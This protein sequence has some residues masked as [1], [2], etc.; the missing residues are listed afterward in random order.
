MW[1]IFLILEKE[2]FINGCMFIIWILVNKNERKNKIFLCNI[3]LFVL[4]LFDIN[5]GLNL[6]L[7]IVLL[8]GFVVVF[9]IFVV[10]LFVMLRYIIFMYFYEL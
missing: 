1:L 3:I 5:E 10:V 8:V 7:I 2:I 4:E 9:F 6:I